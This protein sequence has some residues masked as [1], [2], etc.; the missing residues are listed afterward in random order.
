MLLRQIGSNFQQLDVLSLCHRIIAIDIIASHYSSTLIHFNHALGPSRSPG[1]VA[2]Q[3]V[4]DGRLKDD[5]EE[6]ADNESADDYAGEV[7]RHR[8][9]AQVDQLATGAKDYVENPGVRQVNG[10]RHS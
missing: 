8:A 5:I 1:L 6:E 9:R 3:C 4:N 10:V 2:V 7:Q